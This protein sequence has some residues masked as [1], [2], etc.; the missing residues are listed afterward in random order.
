[1]FFPSWCMNAVKN[2]QISYVN[3]SNE[4]PKKIIFYLK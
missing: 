3:N 1:M 4:A 2:E